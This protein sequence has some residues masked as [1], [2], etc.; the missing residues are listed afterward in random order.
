MKHD[1]A[2]KSIN[3]LFFESGSTI[4][5]VIGEYAM[6]LADPLQGSIVRPQT[7]LT[8][9]M[10]ALTAL[11]N[12]VDSVIP[13]EGS[14][15]TR[16]F[17]FFPFAEKEDAPLLDNTTRNRQLWTEEALA[18]SR[19]KSAIDQCDVVIATCSNF[20]FL[21]GPLVGRRANAITKHAMYVGK[22]RRHE[23]V[24]MFHFEKII[25]IAK[26][27]KGMQSPKN[28]CYCVFPI[29]EKAS[30][31]F[32]GSAINHW[33]DDWINNRHNH[34]AAEFSNGVS[35]LANPKSLPSAISDVDFKRSWFDCGEH[36]RLLISLPERVLD[37][38]RL[39]L[40]REIQFANEL[41]SKYGVF[42]T[43]NSSDDFVSN[44][45]VVEVEMKAGTATQS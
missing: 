28:T 10:F 23:F 3:T 43:I 31:R 25:P 6:A 38:A 11:V 2:R 35:Q 9:N 33:H 13:I 1:D 29:P 19:L 34:I 45:H 5:P 27:V 37:E 12:L 14:F 41:T 15:R 32:K 39:W 7:V 40:E 8:N 36:V 21:A 4:C 30:V 16:Y 24:V 17:G 22:N 42:Y 20:S 18:Y 44:H 26:D